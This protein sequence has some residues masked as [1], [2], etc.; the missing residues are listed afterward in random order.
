MPGEL[1]RTARFSVAG[2]HAA[3]VH[4]RVRLDEQRW[5]LH[6]FGPKWGPAVL[7]WMRLALLL[8]AA[9]LAGAS[10]TSEIFQSR[11]A[12]TATSLQDYGRG[13]FTTATTL[14]MSYLPN[15][16]EL[17]A[18]RCASVIRPLL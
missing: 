11:I 12:E 1:A 8:G 13:D 15:S 9:L 6:P 18:Q 2:A 17:I 7:F 4:V 10:L 3:N 14:R 16:L 5:L